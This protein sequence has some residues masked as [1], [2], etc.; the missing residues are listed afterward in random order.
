[1]TGDPLVLHMSK[2]VACLLFGGSLKV[3]S[4]AISTLPGLPF[5]RP[6]GISAAQYS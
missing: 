2:S 3:P 6:A 1:M 5:V 4:L